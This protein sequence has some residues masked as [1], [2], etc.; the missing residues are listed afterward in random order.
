MS[1]NSFIEEDFE[2]IYDREKAQIEEE[3]RR[4]MLAEWEEWDITQQGCMPERQP[5]KIIV[6]TPKKKEAEND[7]S[8]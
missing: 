1:N 6:E 8:G 4:R 7:H 2:R 3:N 5:A